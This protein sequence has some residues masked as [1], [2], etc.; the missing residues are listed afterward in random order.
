MMGET[1]MI[2]LT[3]GKKQ[4]NHIRLKMKQNYT[5]T[6]KFGPSSGPK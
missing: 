6:F 1:Y 3:K 2:P 4:N 5:N